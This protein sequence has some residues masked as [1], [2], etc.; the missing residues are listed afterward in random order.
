MMRAFAAL[1][2][3]V[4]SSDKETRAKLLQRSDLNETQREVLETYSRFTVAAHNIS[5]FGENILSRIRE[6]GRLHTQYN[7]HLAETGRMTSEKPNFQ[8]FPRDAALRNC[9]LA[10]P[11]G[12]VITA[13]FKSQELAVSAALSGDPV[14]KA[15]LAAGRDLY[16][17][18]ATKVFS[19][20]LAQVTKEQRYQ[21][22]VALLGI[23]YGLSV[24][25]LEKNNQIPPALGTKIIREIRTRYKDLVAWS[26]GLVETATRERVVETAAG[27]KRYFR[28][29]EM[30]S[31]KLATE[32][33]N[34][35]VQGTAA[36]IVYRV[37][38]RL[39]DAL[40][41]FPESYIAN[42]VHDEMVVVC[43]ASLSAQ[44]SRTVQDEMS[45]GFNDI[46]PESIYGVRCGADVHIAPYWT[47]D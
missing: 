39:S 40:K 4:E 47:K 11:G 18:L 42:V 35:P 17:E 10:D 24:K 14:M 31:W 15:D 36:D 41:A 13:D 16:K 33:R 27:S 21:C 19:V 8:N 6:T 29:L 1:G 3:N 37:I 22:K 45:A 44:V 32:A 7:I 23:T 28:D 9:F 26:D 12:V 34:A 43:P 38:A 30:P 46:L 2:F 20:P 5:A 25:G